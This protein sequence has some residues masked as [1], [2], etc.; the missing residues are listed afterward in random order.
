M[1]QCADELVARAVG[2]DADALGT[3]LEEYGPQVRQKLVISPAWQSALDSADVMQVTYM[4]AFLRIGQLATR[5]ARGFAA[6]L[7]GLAQNNL[8]DAVKE[9]KRRKRPDPRRRITAGPN[10]E[11]YAVLLDAVGFTT[12]TASRSLAAR[13]AQR[14]LEAAIARLP[15]SYRKV[16]RLYDLESRPVNEVAER[17]Q[18][19]PGAVYML[20]ARAHD[21]LHELLGSTSRFFSDRA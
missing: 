2:G 8:R 9:L 14:L 19:S 18:R 15:E 7:T 1:G 12:H 16:V 6:W 13:E 3:L 4:E 11:S 5:D 21:R 17:L 10:E 20:R